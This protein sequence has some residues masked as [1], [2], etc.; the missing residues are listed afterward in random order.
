VL[1]STQVDQWLARSCLKASDLPGKL[2][3]SVDGRTIDF[4]DLMG[5]PVPEAT[6]T[7]YFHPTHGFGALVDGKQIE[8]P[9]YRHREGVRPHLYFPFNNHQSWHQWAVTKTKR[10]VM[11]VEGAAKAACCCKFGFDNTVGVLGCWAWR[12]VRHGLLVLPE[13]NEIAV[14][15]CDLYWIPDHDRKHR[16][17]AD[18]LRASSAFARYLTDNRGVRVHVV[19]LPLLEGY[20]KVGVD[21]F[22]HHYSRG[23]KDMKAGRAALQELLDATPVWRDFENTEPGDAARWCSLYGPQF[24]YVG[25]RRTWLWY[26][27]TRW[28][29]DVALA[30]QETVK[31]MYADLLQDARDTGNADL[32]GLLMAT[33]TEPRIMHVGKLVRSDPAVAATPAQF[34]AHPLWVNCLNGTLELP[35]R[36]DG[37]VKGELKF[38]PHTPDDML[39]KQVAVAYDP[40]AKCPVFEQAMVF[41]TQ[42][43]KK[44][45]QLVQQLLGLSLTGLTREQVFILLYGDTQT[46]KSTLLETVRQISGTYSK[47]LSAETLLLRRNDQPEER[48]LASLPGVRFAVASESE[49]RGV[50]DENLI[51]LLTGEDTVTARRLYQEQFDFMPEAKTWLRTNNKP[52]IRSTDDSL[53][54]RLIVLPFGHRVSAK[55]KDI[56][57][58]QKLTAEL[59]GIFA[60]MLRGYLDY[61]EYGLASAPVV[62]A[63]KA[64]YKKEQDVLQRFIDERCTLAPHSKVTPCCVRRDQLYAV[65]VGWCELV[66]I[67]NKMTMAEFRDQLMRRYQ[68]LVSRQTTSS[69]KFIKQE[70]M[71]LGITL[72]NP[73]DMG[74]TKY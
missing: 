54:R 38:R 52:E 72:Q 8:Q 17:V 45:Q 65:Y 44:L 60:W 47:V 73:A 61:A 18:I 41:W 30:Q 5:Q 74:S 35:D 55:Q 56:N 4:Q 39:T 50:L 27:G 48:K 63:A 43:D 42:G 36:V 7:R 9:K 19:W 68:L 57:L 62:E 10:T 23:G 31:Q 16:A 24:R 15:D 11:L 29:D 64:A 26:E 2:L 34:D 40:D 33:T 14:E 1:L 3:P 58:R 37:K 67:R 6:V 51:K 46:G 25:Q 12:A 70:W 69:G 13:F 49:K 21:D 32:C 22:L 71:W 28:T 53:W 20:D 59:P 66:G